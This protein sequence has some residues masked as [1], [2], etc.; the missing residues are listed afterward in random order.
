MSI[1]HFFHIAKKGI[2]E[3]R[4]ILLFQH[5]VC[6]IVRT[7]SSCTSVQEGTNAFKQQESKN[8][9][10]GIVHKKSGSHQ[11]GHSFIREGKSPDDKKTPHFVLTFFANFHYFCVFFLSSCQ[12]S[13]KPQHFTM[14]HYSAKQHSGIIYYISQQSHVTHQLVL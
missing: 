11:S 14:H 2:N 13:T 5:D 3:S 7:R 4:M 6:S 12:N 10:Q 9:E 8:N 1:K